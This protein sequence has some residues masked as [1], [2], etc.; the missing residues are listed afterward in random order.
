MNE[1]RSYMEVDRMRFTKNTA[2]SRLAILAIVFNVLY[3]ISIYKS[4]VGNY[5][6]TAL[7]GVSIVYNLVFMLTTF[8][9]SEGVKNYNRSYSKVLIIVGILQIVRIFILPLKMHN[10][11]MSSAPVESTLHILNYYIPVTKDLVVMET[12][13]FVRVVI[14]LAASA[15]CLFRSAVINLKKSRALNDHIAN[16]SSQA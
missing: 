10:T 12:W 2:S 4:D 9:C 15:F 11:L 5:Y 6:Y 14:Y 8:L 1:E 13:Q 16:L 3:F 7:I